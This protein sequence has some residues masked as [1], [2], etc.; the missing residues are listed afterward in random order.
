MILCCKGTHGGNFRG[1]IAIDD[2]RVLPNAACILPTTTTTTTTTT[3]PG[4]HTPL[5]CDFEKDM[6]KWT[7]D[8]AASGKWSRR[9]GQASGFLP[10][11]HYGK[12]KPNS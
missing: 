4:R 2:I 3:T 7:H 12:I 8:I 5:S 6:C 1:D 10:G 11:P 9:Q